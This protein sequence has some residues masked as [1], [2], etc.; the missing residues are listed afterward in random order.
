ML[1]QQE[2]HDLW[3]RQMDYLRDAQEKMVSRNTHFTLGEDAFEH[4]PAMIKEIHVYLRNLLNKRKMAGG[5]M[6]QLMQ[7]VN[8]MSLDRF[9]VDVLATRAQYERSDAILGGM[10]VRWTPSFLSTCYPRASRSLIGSFVKD[11]RKLSIGLVLALHVTFG[12]E[13]FVKGPAN[14]F[15]QALS[16]LR[17]DGFLTLITMTYGH[18]GDLF[19]LLCYP[20]RLQGTSVELNAQW[21]TPS[22]QKMKDWKTFLIQYLLH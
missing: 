1:V 14:L 10:G 12:H 11:I 2:A 13:K 16:D 19:A 3:F 17:L 21:E 9:H 20:E 5:K 4:A 18:L 22:Y 8:T 15:T 7:D 6:L